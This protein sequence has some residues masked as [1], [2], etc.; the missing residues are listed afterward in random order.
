MK[1]TEKTSLGARADMHLHSVY[2]DGLNTPEEICCL[3]K[4][5]GL[6]AI[7]IT[8]HDTMNGDEEKR[9]AAGKY[10][11]AY[12][13]GWEISAYDE[14]LKLHILGY[15]CERGEAYTRF[16]QDRKA[17]SLAR[18]EESVAKLRAL[19]VP[20]TMDDV[21]SFQTDK[22]APLHTMHV[23]RAAAKYL[24]LSTRE[25]YERYL[26]V[27]MPANS[28]IGRPTPK[29]AIACIHASGGIASI[30]HPGRIT[31][32]DDGK[33]RIVRSLAECGVDG[34]EAFYTT[35]T[36]KE[37]AWFCTLAKEL[38]LYITGGSDTH[39]EDGTHAVGLP[40]F[41][42]ASALQKRLFLGE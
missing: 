6:Q 7:S 16:M 39:I 8:D 4:M 3:A 5:R 20:V 13:S 26:N 25:T 38:G 24:G 27:G 22:T 18:A 15:A 9:A 34:I 37:T 11:L 31:L 28:S 35:H 33:E 30:A 42:M 1:D 14:D 41:F 32:D 10:G 36:E 12:V 29:E 2:S 23:T 21:L 19:G 40:V 17:A